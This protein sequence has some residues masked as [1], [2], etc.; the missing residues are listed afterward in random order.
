MEA[1]S[2]GYSTKNIP[3]SNKDVYLKELISKREHFFRKIRWK[4]YHFLKNNKEETETE[5]FGFRTLNTPPKNQILYNFENDLYEM[6]RKTEFQP[7]KNEFQ[8][9]LSEDLRSIKR[10]NKIF[11]SAD[12]TRN[13]YGLDPKEYDKLLNNNV[14]K[15]YKKSNIKTVNEINKEANILTEKLKINDRVQCIAQNEAFITI[16]DHKPN[17]PNNIACRLLN[18]CK[19]EIGKVSK[20]YLE[21]INNSIRSSINL[22]QWRNSKTVID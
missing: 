16:K 6:I 9:K 5:N 7:V 21:N 11:V 19:S 10:S 1:K 12:K 15:S 8:R 20:V 22:N 13:M 2:L 17:F 4:I 3:L 14:T 18:P